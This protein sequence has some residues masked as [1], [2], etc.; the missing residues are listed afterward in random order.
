MVGVN[1]DCYRAQ[2]YES[3]RLLADRL[4]VPPEQRVVCFQSRLGRDPWIKPY[5]DILVRE[6][7]EQ[8]I[9]RAVI[10]SP[11][12]VADCLETIEELGIR[13]AEDFE[14]H[15]GEKLALVPSL[16]AMDSWADAVVTLARE[17]SSWLVPGASRAVADSGGARG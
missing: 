14:A 4:A 13:A 8:G 11:A 3:A 9:K 6:A 7:A 12:F 10:L 5:T 16:N 2:C 15:G 1:A 17:T